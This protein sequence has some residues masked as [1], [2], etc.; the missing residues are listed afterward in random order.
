MQIKIEQGKMIK[1]SN[2]KVGDIFLHRNDA[3]I[4]ISELLDPNEDNR[5]NAVYLGNGNHFFFANDYMVERVE[6]ELTVRR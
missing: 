6:A 4:C 5:Y 2:I 3:Y 1:F